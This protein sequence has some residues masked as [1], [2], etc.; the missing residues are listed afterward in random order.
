MI[1]KLPRL[2]GLV[3][4]LSASQHVGVAL[5]LGSSGSDLQPIAR[6]QQGGIRRMLT[7]KLVRREC[8]RRSLSVVDLRRTVVDQPWLDQ[9]LN[10]SIPLAF[11][12][13]PAA[14]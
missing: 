10:R 2:V 11:L 7:N 9:Y 4:A 1:V 6:R 8:P 5:V 3:A 14:K 13:P 12:A